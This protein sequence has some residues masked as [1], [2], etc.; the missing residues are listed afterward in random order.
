MEQPNEST[1]KRKKK[2]MRYVAGALA[3]VWAGFW[4]FFGLAS[5]I[6]EGLSLGRV[7]AHT[8]MPGLIFLA[9]AVV[10]WRTH[11]IGAAVLLIEGLVVLIAYPIM[12][13]HHFP[14]STIVFVLLT[15]ALP[16]LVAGF[17]FISSART[18]RNNN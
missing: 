16:P 15:M 18:A 10:A 12:T 13:Y 8:T 2:W 7:L 6:G 1:A 11:V 9:S 4:S 17:L 3:L 5:G 14:Y